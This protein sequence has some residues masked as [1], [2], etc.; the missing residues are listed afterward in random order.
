MRILITGAT[1]MIGKRLLRSFAKDHVTILSRHPLRAA[2]SLRAQRFVEWDG[3]SA[4]D[5]RVVSG[6][7]LV[8]HLA[9]EPVA[10]GRWTASKKR[11]ILDSRVLGT[12][13]IV[14]AIRK[15]EHRP[16]VLVNAS[17]VGFYGDRGDEQ[18]T[19]QSAVGSGFLSE[20][21]VGWEHEAQAAQH[22]E[23]RVA[24]LRIGVV[25]AREGGALSKMIPLFKTGLAGKLGDGHQWMPWIHLDDVV[26]LLL[27]AGR[28]AQWQ[29]PINAVAPHPVTNEVFTRKLAQAV[30]R[31]A[32]LPAPS[33]A[34]RLA[35]GELSN[36]V[37]ASQRVIPQAAIDLGYK[38]R[39]PE[40]ES[41]LAAILDKRPQQSALQAQP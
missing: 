6:L 8:Y 3:V 4:L 15:A 25:L 19:E 23:T 10:E 7:D 11:A 27:R 5:P 30:H 39:H 18:L 36:L 28:N 12:R 26:G 20:V 13:A 24:M 16:K 2:Q 40:L 37:L 41:A 29:G 1:G 31:P 33:M 14:A 32:F 22:A 34:L 35:L 38:F 21:C 17:A 9:G